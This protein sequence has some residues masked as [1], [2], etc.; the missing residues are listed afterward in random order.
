MA[1]EFAIIC[2]PLIALFLAAMQLGVIFLVNQMMQDAVTTASREIRTGQIQTGGIGSVSMRERICE[3]L[4]LVANCPANLQ[5]A[6]NSFATLEDAANA[7]L[8]TSTGAPIINNEYDPGGPNEIVVV[9]IAITYPIGF[10]NYFA[11]EDGSAQRLAVS[12]VARSE[13]YEE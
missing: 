3:D 13:N 1:V 2:L 11:P 12:M 4:V 6:V 10:V 8:Y 9:S 5:L 7:D